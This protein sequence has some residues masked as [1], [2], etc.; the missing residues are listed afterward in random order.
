MSEHC[1][2]CSK[3]RTSLAL[4]S[5]DCEGIDQ[6]REVERLR[7]GR[8]PCRGCNGKDSASVLNALCYSCRN[9][10]ARDLAEKEAEIE[11][12]RGRVALLETLKAGHPAMC[13]GQCA[14]LIAKAEQDIEQLTLALANERLAMNRAVAEI[15][16]LRVC[17]RNLLSETDR[18]FREETYSRPYW[19]AV[20]EA[21]RLL[22]GKP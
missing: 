20:D 4:S 5:G 12:L 10:P 7:A 6:T 1:H 13:C 22:E 16:G 11:R 17:L 18:A 2:G 14:D 21:E 15:R 8:V 19:D 3:R 9:K